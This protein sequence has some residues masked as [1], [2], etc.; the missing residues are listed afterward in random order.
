MQQIE[1]NF[2]AANEKEN[3]ATMEES[4]HVENNS[5][6]LFSYNGKRLHVVIKDKEVW[7]DAKD[8]SNILG[9]RDAFNAI[10]RLDNN[11]RGVVTYTHGGMQDTIAISESGLR[12]LVLKS[13]EGKRFVYWIEHEVLPQTNMR[14]SNTNQPTPAKTEK[15]KHEE[16]IANNRK[17]EFHMQLL[18]TKQFNGISLDCYRDS[19]SAEEENDFWATREQ[20]GRL[21][22]YERPN[23]AI[24]HIHDRNKERLDKFSTLLKMGKV[25]G[26]RTVTRD[27]T[28]YNFKGLLEICRYSNQPNANR[29]MDFLWEVADE[30][31]T[32]GMYITPT[33][34]QEM[35]KDPDVWIQVLQTL[36]AEQ[37]KVKALNAKIEEDRPKVEFAEAL[38]VSDKSV[39]VNHLAKILQ[40]NGIEIGQNELFEWLRKNGYL[41]ESRGM[42]RNLPTQKSSE[43]GLFEVK[44]TVVNLGNGK[45]TTKFTPLVTVKGQEY[46]IRKFLQKKEKESNA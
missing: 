6:M 42:R 27:V 20:I 15:E 9:F 35:M 32:K 13:N 44:T 8:V 36:K 1:I 40:Q 33:K 4:I 29:V 7:F 11:E 19:N 14:T 24:A 31:R 21:L 10:R 5:L 18:T 2:E 46:F 16:Y 17:G 3:Q 45:T 26:N 28:V 41:M 25:E 43:L 12:A 38:K 34:M 22:G 23:E 37:Q 30:I 39:L